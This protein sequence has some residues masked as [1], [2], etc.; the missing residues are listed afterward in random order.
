MSPIRPG[1]RTPGFYETAQAGGRTSTETGSASNNIPGRHSDNESVPRKAEIGSKI[2]VH[3]PGV[4]R[5]CDKPEEVDSKSSAVPGILRDAPGLGQH[6]NELVG[7]ETDKDTQQMCQPAETDNGIS[8]RGREDNRDIIINHLGSVTSATAL[9]AAANAEI[10]SSHS[11]QVLQE[12][13]HTHS[14]GEY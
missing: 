11:E 9:S 5:V 3:S 13:G 14:R 7:R 4:S 2:A 1:L 10:T 8:P 12:H 6:D